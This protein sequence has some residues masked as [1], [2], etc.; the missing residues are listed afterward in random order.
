MC[1]A[2]FL[3]LLLAF[4]TGC[5]LGP[6]LQLAGGAAEKRAVGWMRDSSAHRSM[7][8]LPDHTYTL[9]EDVGEVSVGGKQSVKRSGEWQNVGNLLPLVQLDDGRRFFGM[10]WTPEQAVRAVQFG[11]VAEGWVGSAGSC[12]GVV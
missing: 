9:V 6:S 11:R 1:R 2:G 12:G 10:A 5:P 8:L 3:G 7:V 4:L